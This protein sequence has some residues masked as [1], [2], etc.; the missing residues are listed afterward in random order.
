MDVGP[1]ILDVV[2]IPA[3]DHF[4]GA[5]LLPL[6]GGEVSD[7]FDSRR[8]YSRGRWEGVSV[9]HGNWKLLADSGKPKLFNLDVD[10]GEER[11]LADLNGPLVTRLLGEAKAYIALQEKIASATKTREEGDTV[12][13]DQRAI[14]QLKAL[15]YLK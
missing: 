5:S 8:I 15:G 14:E 3:P 6:V 10:F 9:I 2:G 4:Q 12:T 11:N 13:F 7:V 1:T